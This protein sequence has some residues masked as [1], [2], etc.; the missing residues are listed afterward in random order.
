MFKI[1]ALP[2]INNE[3]NGVNNTTQRKEYLEGI[4][5]NPPIAIAVSI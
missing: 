3:I 5:K 1:T 2:E 4:I